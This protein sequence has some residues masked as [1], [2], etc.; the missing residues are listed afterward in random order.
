MT[1]KLQLRDWREGE[2]ISVLEFENLQQVSH[3]YIMEKPYHTSVKCDKDDK[4][5]ERE[6]GGEERKRRNIKVLV[7]EGLQQVGQIFL[8]AI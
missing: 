5:L 7:F 4:R 1:R 3:I 2:R 8:L 6:G